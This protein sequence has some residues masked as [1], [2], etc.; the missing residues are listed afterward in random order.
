MESHDG[1]DEFADWI[2]SGGLELMAAAGLWWDKPM[3]VL[4]W[5][6]QPASVRVK[7]V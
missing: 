5:R 2:L 3:M 6:G 4:G 1:C 7:P